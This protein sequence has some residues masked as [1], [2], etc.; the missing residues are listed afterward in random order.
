[1]A[2]SVVVKKEEKVRN[3]FLE[4]GIDISEEE[5]IENFK[6]LHPK[7]WERIVSRYN[8]EKEKTKPGKKHPMPEPNKYLSNTYK[9]YKKKLLQEAYEKNNMTER[10]I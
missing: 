9:V 5:F 1:M 10:N 6:S 4:K 2:Q 8:K 7:D 3:I